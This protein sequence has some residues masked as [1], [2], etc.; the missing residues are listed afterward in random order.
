MSRDPLFEAPLSG[1][2]FRLHTPW[3]PGLDVRMTSPFPPP[4]RIRNIVEV[5]PAGLGPT[6]P[7]SDDPAPL[8]WRDD[9]HGVLRY[10]LRLETRQPSRADRLRHAETLSRAT[11]GRAFGDQ[12]PAEQRRLLK[13]AEGELRATMRPAERHLVGYATTTHV[14]IPLVPM[15]DAMAPVVGCLRHAF[16]TM[17]L[18]GDLQPLQSRGWNAMAWLIVQR[19]LETPDGVLSASC[20]LQAVTMKTD[21]CSFRSTNWDEARP[22]VQRL[23]R[24]RPL[25]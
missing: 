24:R 19:A 12:G 6:T 14:W 10:G 9:G 4:P 17:T 7:W 21:D 2:L 1:R 18:V 3:T 25:P 22:H 16:G 20:R 5:H 8:V 23:F 11:A 13:E 15:G